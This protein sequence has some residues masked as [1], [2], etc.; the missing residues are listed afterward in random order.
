MSSK[1]HRPQNAASL[2]K[3]LKSSAGTI[4]AWWKRG[5]LE[6]EYDRERDCYLYW[7]PGGQEEELRAD[8]AG[9]EAQIEE[10]EARLE[11][12]ERKDGA[13]AKFNASLAEIDRDTLH[14]LRSTGVE[15]RTLHEGV[16]QLVERL[17]NASQAQLAAEEREIE[18]AREA[19]ELREALKEAAAGIDAAHDE[20][21]SLRD[22]AR[23]AL[24]KAEV[25]AHRLKE[26]CTRLEDRNRQLYE[27]LAALEL[28][29]RARK[30][31]WI[32][33]AAR[34]LAHTVKLMAGRGQS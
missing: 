10:L 29:L 27:Q 31:D 12:L 32:L 17:R 14:L 3:V 21:Q 4:N 34:S 9:A 24:L 28:Q 6:R 7:V 20:L 8:L 15:A 26:H 1:K 30:R 5:L 19:D 13:N 2:A 25:E 11:L 18:A 23:D 33:G 22:T 16:E